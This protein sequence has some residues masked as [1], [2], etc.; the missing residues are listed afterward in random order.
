[1][2]V[3]VCVY[4]F[5]N[6]TVGGLGGFRGPISA[7]PKLSVGNFGTNPKQMLSKPTVWFGWFLFLC[8][9]INYVFFSCD[10]HYLNK[11][12]LQYK[13]ILLCCSTST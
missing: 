12:C 13:I 9:N 4:D 10:S 2:C 11:I 8:H 1:M 5:H 7:E 6:Y 3:C